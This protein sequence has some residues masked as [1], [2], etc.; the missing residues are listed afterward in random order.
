M[1]CEYTVVYV[2]SIVC[3]KYYSNIIIIVGLQILI[4]GGEKVDPSI[5]NKWPLLV[6]LSVIRDLGM[7][8]PPRRKSFL[9]STTQN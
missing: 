9:M 8:A 4:V 7:Q 1:Q 2:H 5:Q 6:E 3:N